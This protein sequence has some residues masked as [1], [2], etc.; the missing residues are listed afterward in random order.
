MK[1]DDDRHWIAGM[2]YYNPED[3]RIIVPT[4]STFL[5]GLTLNMARKVSWVLIA[6][7]NTAGFVLAVTLILNHR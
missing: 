1:S 7:G 6:V 2:I 5:P 3:R 4:R